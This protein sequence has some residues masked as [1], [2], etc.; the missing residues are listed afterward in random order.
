MIEI[1]NNLQHAIEFGILTVGI[2]GIVR[3]VMNLSVKFMDYLN[4]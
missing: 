3:A 4:K 1:G 2:V